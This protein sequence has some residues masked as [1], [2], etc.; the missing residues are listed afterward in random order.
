MDNYTVCAVAGQADAVLRVADSIPIRNNSL[1][2]PYIV[3]SCL[4]VMHTH[5]CLFVNKTTTQEAII[6]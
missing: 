3:V 2:G 5:D 6:G 4:G 1:C